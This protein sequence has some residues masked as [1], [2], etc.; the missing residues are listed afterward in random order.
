[1]S[2]KNLI[3]YFRHKLLENYDKDYFKIEYLKNNNFKYSFIL[4]NLIFNN[5]FF[6]IYYIITYFN[7]KR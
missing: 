3:F 7:I 1:M 5:T 4:K 6:M 2:H